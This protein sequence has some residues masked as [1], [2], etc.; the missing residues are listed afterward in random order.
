MK[1]FL[2]SL[3]TIFTAK[4]MTKNP[5]KPLGDSQAAWNSFAFNT[6][7]LRPKKEKSWMT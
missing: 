3:V 6:E 2:I 7:K 4:T 5:P 1:N